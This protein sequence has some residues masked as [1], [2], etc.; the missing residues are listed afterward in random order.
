MRFIEN[1]LVEF[2]PGA[3]KEQPPK[4]ATLSERM[5]HYKIPGVS[6]ALINENKIEWAK[7]YGVINVE[8][9]VPVTKESFFEAASTTKMLVA[10]TALHFVEKGLLDLDAD[11]NNYLKSWKIPESDLT[12]EKKITLRLLLT[13]QSGLHS[14]NFPRWKFSPP[15]QLNINGRQVNKKRRLIIKRQKNLLWPLIALIATI[16]FLI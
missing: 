10:A 13:H 1:N 12:K 11:V 7:S 5:S 3:G 16:G 14:A 4:R 8:S 15:L 9:R 6:I 2:N